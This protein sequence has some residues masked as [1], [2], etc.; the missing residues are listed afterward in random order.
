MPQEIP[1]IQCLSKPGGIKTPH[2]IGMT[3]CSLHN[4]IQSHMEGQGNGN[5]SKNPL[6]RHD[7]EKHNGE[8]AG[9]VMLIQTQEF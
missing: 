7:K 2:Y 9:T 4:R 1:T 3:T 5:S 6:V 8:T